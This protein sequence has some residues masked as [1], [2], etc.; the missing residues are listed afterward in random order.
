M[1]PCILCIE[2]ETTLLADVD[3]E[4]TAAGYR[5]ISA[6]SAEQALA[7]LDAQHPD[8]ILCD[9]RAIIDHQIEVHRQTLSNLS[10]CAIPLD[11]CHHGIIVSELDI[12][13][14]N[15]DSHDYCLREK[16]G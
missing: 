15:I 7:L 9:V 5:V 14:C 10:R 3:E 11:I 16:L 6:T 2:D 4:L 12:I 1:S 8:L 13:Q